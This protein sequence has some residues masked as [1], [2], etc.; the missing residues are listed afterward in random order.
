KPRRAKPSALQGSAEVR[1]LD[2]QYW[3][4][5]PDGDLRVQACVG[6]IRGPGFGWR[7]PRPRWT[8]GSD[9]AW[10]FQIQEVRTMRKGCFRDLSEHRHES[11][12]DCISALG[13]GK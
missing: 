5:Q 2:L 6:K 10:H 8:A 12:R 4:G 9:H 1:H 11:R 7:C 13:V 3:R